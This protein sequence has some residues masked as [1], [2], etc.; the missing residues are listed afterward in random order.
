MSAPRRQS[1]RRRADAAR[2]PGDDDCSVHAADA[3]E[4]Y[5]RPGSAPPFTWIT[6]AVTCAAAGEAR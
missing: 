2:A 6:C 3:I 5:P 4:G 1:G